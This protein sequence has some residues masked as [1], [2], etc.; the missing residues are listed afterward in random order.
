MS[1]TQYCI[2]NLMQSVVTR[3]SKIL[4][5]LSYWVPMVAPCIISRA[6]YMDSTSL[7]NATL[8]SDLQV[9][10]RPILFV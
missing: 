3:F 1:L 6:K 4:T 8:G 5:N 7:L 9:Q 2:A 10:N